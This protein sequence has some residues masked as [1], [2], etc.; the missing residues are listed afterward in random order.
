VLSKF[1]VNKQKGSPN[2]DS[3]I[4]LLVNFCGDSP[5]CRA[6]SLSRWTMPRVSAGAAHI[7]CRRANASS[8][9]RRKAVRS[10]GNNGP[11]RGADPR[12][13][14]CGMSWKICPRN[15]EGR[16]ECLPRNSHGDDKRRAG[17]C[18]YEHKR[19]RLKSKFFCTKSPCSGSR[20]SR[21]V[22]TVGGRTVDGRAPAARW[23]I[24]PSAGSRAR[25]STG[26]VGTPAQRSRGFFCCRVG[27]GWVQISREPRRPSSACRKPMISL[28]VWLW[29]R[30]DEC[31][32]LLSSG[33][34][35]YTFYGLIAQNLSGANDH[36]LAIRG[37]S[38]PMEWWDDFERSAS[39]SKSIDRCAR[40]RSRTRSSLRRAPRL[41]APATTRNRPGPTGAIPT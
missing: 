33:E 30:R 6:L 36:V 11:A 31:Y 23:S 14:L 12:R 10:G 4:R 18:G 26:L 16:P 15:T 5:R 20:C 24:T 22:P 29:H 2:S 17:R 38:N 8:A 13:R 25:L 39:R 7:F 32:A 21:P 27:T 37:T 28:S 34:S 3:N 41:S 40:L 9:A 19:H 35:P 1:L